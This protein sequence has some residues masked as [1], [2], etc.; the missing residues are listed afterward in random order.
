MECKSHALRHF[1]KGFMLYAQCTVVESY[2]LTDK[3][4]YC[5]MAVTIATILVSFVGL[6]ALYNRLSPR[7]RLVEIQ[8]TDRVPIIEQEQTAGMS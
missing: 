7:P 1:Q 6:V 5:P 3:H 8:A 2:E 4:T